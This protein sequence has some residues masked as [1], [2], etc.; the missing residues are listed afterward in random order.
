MATIPNYWKV[1][2]RP[3]LLTKDV[4]NDYIALVSTS[5]ETL[6]NEHIARSIVLEGSEY[7]LD[8]LVSIL[9]QADRVVREKLQQGYSVM[10]GNCHFTPRVLGTWM[11][12]TALFDPSYHRLTCDMVPTQTLRD[13]FKVVN[14]EVLGVKDSGCSA[15]LVTNTATGK[16]DGLIAPGDDIIIDGDKIRIA[17]ENEEGLGVFF[18]D[19]TGNE[20]PVTVRLVQN[21]PK[22]II[23]RVPD[24]APNKAYKLVIRTRFAASNTLLKN[25]REIE[26]EQ[27]LTHEGEGI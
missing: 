11:G 3:N 13:A 27:T 9:N 4:D 7:K 24:I 17:P 1:W 22:R 14:V 8:T 15:G 18:V 19:E 10:T 20:K 6:R 23:C 25:M 26:Y 12:S 21:S 5:K 16:T 2:L